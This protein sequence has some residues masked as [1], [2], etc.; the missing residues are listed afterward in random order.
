MLSGSCL[1]G[2]VRYESRGPAGP[3]LNC[4]CETCRKAHGAAFSTTTRVPREGFR[5][6][7]GEEILSSYESSPGKRRFFCSRCGSQ[8]IAAWDS[9][10]E[11]IIRVGSLDTDP[12]SKP[13]LQIWTDLKAP[14]Y[15]LDAHLPTIPRGRER[16]S[17]TS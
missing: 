14:W 13:V 6:T 10:A 1:C 15:E 16:G 17:P 9:E 2:G 8:L 3:L 4:H 7:T 11:I 12:G 5:W